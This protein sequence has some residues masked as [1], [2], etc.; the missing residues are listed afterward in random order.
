M[1]SLKETAVFFVWIVV[2][3]VLSPYR[4]MACNG[5]ECL[6]DT[7][8]RVKPA[9]VGIGTVQKTRRPPGVLGGTGFVI[10]DGNHVITN[11][12][13]IPEKFN[14]RYHEFLAVFTGRDRNLSVTP[15]EVVLTDREHDLALLKIPGDPLPVL[16]LGNDETVREGEVYALSG[17]PLGA[18]LGLHVVT[19][20]C[21]ISAI[22]PIILPVFRGRKLDQSRVDLL[23]NPF[24]VF[25]LDGT[26]YPGNSGSPLYDIRTGAVV[27][28]VNMVLVKGAKENAITD[29]SGITYAI[30]LRH[31]KAILKKAGLNY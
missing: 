8:E 21:L 7:I 27:G 14:T 4:A 12:H 17:Y 1:T 16:T 26:A 23:I 25:Q 10:A 29:P 6:P 11:A 13:V 19:H 28:I 2:C 20:H 3:L 9:I 31:V 30:P 22:T 24:D 15:A 18:A 5:I